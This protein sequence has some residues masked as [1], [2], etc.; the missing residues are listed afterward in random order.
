MT[1]AKL[2][3]EG[4]V[5]T[6]LVK[7]HA[8]YAAEGFDIVCSAVSI[9]LYTLAEFLEKHPEI[10][11]ES[12]IEKGYAKITIDAKTS[13][14]KNAVELL[15]CGFEILDN[16]APDYFEFEQIISS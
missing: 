5:Y 1:K 16:M 10:K 3:K 9:I 14:A 8:G 2:I 4:D 15:V 13:D 7:G 11:S 6:A 12:V